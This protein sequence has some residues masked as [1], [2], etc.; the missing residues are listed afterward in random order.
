MS[1]PIVDNSLVI[2]LTIS[3]YI[4]SVNSSLPGASRFLCII[5]ALLMIV[6]TYSSFSGE[7][8]TKRETALKL[9]V[10]TL[11]GIVAGCF[12]GC[13]VFVMLREVKNVY[14]VLTAIAVFV[15]QCLL[16]GRQKTPAYHI[17]C[18]LILVMVMV[19]FLLAFYAV[20]I[21]QV[22]KKSEQ[23][24]LTLSNI[25]ELHEKRLNEQL[26]LQNMM[27]EKN[28]RLMERENISRNIHNSVGHSITA[29]IMTLD[30]A[31]VLYDVNPEEARKRMNDA[32]E[33]IRGS[34]DSIRRAVRVLDENTTK[35]SFGDLKFEMQTII[36][37]FVMD[38]S[39][40]VSENYRDFP[41]EAL[42][43]HEQAE[44]L[45]GALQELLTNGVK[46][47]NAD[48]F[49]VVLIGDTAHIR[50]LVS[51]NGKNEFHPADQELLIE[52]GFGLKKIISYV[53][54]QGGKTEFIY[55]NGFKARIEFPLFM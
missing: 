54:K 16:F 47:G 1:Y 26:V 33:R 31:D 23:E 43:S 48:E 27:A 22:K 49:A 38:T 35:I 36:H 50:M 41:E 5:A 46:H 32:G 15:V 18:V 7:N 9:A 6:M 2:V 20:E 53:E 8:R 10:M 3:C 19:V 17:V 25:G 13:I 21:F 4:W 51:D 39:I 14:R 44:F 40:H 42:I 12:L 11:Y 24:K 30:A 34:L 52:Q 29:A 55:E 28:A 45:T 37:E